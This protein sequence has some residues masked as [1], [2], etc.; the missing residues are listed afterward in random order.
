M[1]A[2]TTKSRVHDF[3]PT[4]PGGLRFVQNHVHP[5]N[6]A[7]TSQ[8]MIFSSGMIFYLT[9]K[10]EENNDPRRTPSASKTATVSTRSYISGIPNFTEK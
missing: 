1:M 4:H 2:Q 3:R 7:N 8:K 9:I 10:M 5:N 6:N